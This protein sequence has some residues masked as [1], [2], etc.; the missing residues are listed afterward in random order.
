M[1]TDEEEETRDHLELQ[2]EP[3]T[4]LSWHE[5]S[6]L[7]LELTP[8]VFWFFG[9]P[10]S[11]LVSHAAQGR[12]TERGCDASYWWPTWQHLE[13]PGGNLQACLWGS[14]Q[15]RL[16]EERW[17]T[18]NVDGTIPWEG[19][20]LNTNIHFPL[21]PDCRGHPDLPAMIDF[22]NGEPESTPPP[23][24]CFCQVFSHSPEKSS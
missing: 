23:F 12:E 1:K 2:H 18:L 14:V 10:T 8:L 17:P 20:K 9:S 21:L 16:T 4:I 15:I 22:A 6:T 5:S 11:G 13:S 3:S 24:C 7:R 19:C